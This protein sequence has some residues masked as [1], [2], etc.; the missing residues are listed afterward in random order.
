MTDGRASERDVK[1]VGAAA[2]LCQRDE[3]KMERE[4]ESNTL[5][6]L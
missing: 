6:Q 3:G 4:R 2:F 1:L 5:G